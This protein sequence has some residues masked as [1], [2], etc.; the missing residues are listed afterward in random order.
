M[1]SA[2]RQWAGIRQK[3][4]ARRCGWLFVSKSSPR[5]RHQDTPR[6][7]DVAECLRPVLLVGKPLLQ[8][9]QTTAASWQ[10]ALPGFS[11]RP[12]QPGLLQTGF[13]RAALHIFRAARQHICRRVARAVHHHDPLIPAAHRVHFP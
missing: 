4:S 7:P 9:G 2:T 1:I 6:A 5:L 12:S 13:L 8:R 11:P 10:T 3:S